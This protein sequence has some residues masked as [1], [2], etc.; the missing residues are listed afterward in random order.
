MII[1]HDTDSY[2]AIDGYTKSTYKLCYWFSYYDN[3]DRLL[4]YYFRRD[5]KMG[6]INI[7]VFVKENSKLSSLAETAA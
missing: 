6:S 1:L 4:E 3:E 7:D 2:D 5:G